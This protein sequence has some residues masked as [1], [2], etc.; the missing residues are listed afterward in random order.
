[1]E[2]FDESLTDIEK[3]VDL[4]P[5]DLSALRWIGLN[6]VAQCPDEQFRA[7][8]LKL[9]DKA[10]E[11][12]HHSARAYAVRGRLLAAFGREEQAIED[13]ERAFERLPE[14]GDPSI[15][16]ELT[17]ESTSYE[18]S[19]LCAQLAHRDQTMPYLV[20]MTELLQSDVPMVYK[21]FAWA[22][23][24]CPRK[25]LGDA[26]RTVELAKM[27]VEL[28]EKAVEL[29]GKSAEPS[30]ETAM[31]VNTLGVAHCRAGNWDKAIETLNRS[32][33]LRNGGDSFDWFFLAMAHW[34]LAHKDEARQWY[35][36]AV[37]WMEK[38][39][40]DDEA[41]CRFRA[42]AAELLGVTETEPKTKEKPEE[43]QTK[44]SEA[45]AQGSKEAKP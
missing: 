17:L 16:G 30:P 35:G 38:N 37:D 41:L 24:T 8:L 33:E 9:A 25:A 31:S 43:A 6:D 5:D 44:R 12:T 42:E 14:K 28:A 23:A 18:L 15:P 39:K 27:A 3:A 1:M 45:N 13:L 20:K 10:I 7:G 4:K 34:Q 11:L 40:P 22:L 26:N 32:S 19:V 2:N 36:K 21:N 29:A